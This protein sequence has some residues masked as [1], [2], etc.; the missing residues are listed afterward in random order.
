MYMTKADFEELAEAFKI[1]GAIQPLND[2]EQ[3]T[4][5]RVINRAFVLHQSERELADIYVKHKDEI[6]FAAAVAKNAFDGAKLSG[7]LSTNPNTF[8]PRKINAGFFGYD[9]WWKMPSLTA[10][11]LNNWIDDTTPTHL[12]GSNNEPMKVG[13]PAVHLILYVRSYSKS[14]SVELLKIT[15]NDTTLPAVDTTEEF[16]GT[17]LKI[18]ELDTPILLVG[19]SQND[20]FKVQ[21]FTGYGT[22][23]VLALGGISFLTQAAARIYDPVDMAGTSMEYIAVY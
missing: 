23:D 12:G 7:E 6:F 8:I 9:S 19:G 21:V 2:E 5:D 11:Q 3:K 10:G 4:L 18:K 13:K 1:P 16:Y 20:E 15:K 17:D 22:S 14:P